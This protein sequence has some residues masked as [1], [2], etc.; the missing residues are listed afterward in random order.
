[1]VCGVCRWECVWCDKVCVSTATLLLLCCSST[2]MPPHN[3]PQCTHTHT[4]HHTHTLSYPTPTFSPIHTNLFPHTHLF[5]FASCC[6]HMLQKLIH[7]P[8]RRYLVGCHQ[9]LGWHTLHNGPHRCHGVIELFYTHRV[10]QRRHCC[11]ICCNTRCAWSTRCVCWV[12][13]AR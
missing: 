3:N 6:R 12:T 4:Q 9:L 10:S 7:T 5:Q 13:I 11:C 8:K 2:S 1:M